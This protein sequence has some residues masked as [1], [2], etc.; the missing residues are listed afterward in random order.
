M[1]MKTTRLKA[2][3]LKPQCTPPEVPDLTP[4]Q[5]EALHVFVHEVL[6]SL[7][8]LYMVVPPDQADPVIDKYLP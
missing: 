6:A 7:H 2:N 8:R 1:T 3:L 4:Q 5:Q